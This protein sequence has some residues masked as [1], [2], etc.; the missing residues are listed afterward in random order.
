MRRAT[1]V[2]VSVMAAAA[3]LGAPAAFAAKH[4][5]GMDVRAANPHG[6]V[7]AKGAKS[8]GASA[9][10]NPDMLFH[11]GQ[12]MTT[13]NVTPIYWGTSWGNATFVADKQSGLASFYTGFSDSN[14][15]KTS[16]E[17][18]GTNGT[19]GPSN[20]FTTGITDTSPAP[21][22]APST[23]AVLNEVAKFFPNPDPLGYYPVYVDTKRGSAGYCAWHSYGTI[24]GKPVVFAF[25]FNLDGDPGCDPGNKVA[26]H[27][28]G[29]AALANVS[30]HELSEARTD[31][32]NG[33]WYDASGG[34]NGDKC[35]WTFN[36]PSVT[37]SNGSQWT[38]QGEW[39][40]QAYDSQTGYPN[41]SGQRGCLDG[42]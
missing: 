19:V 38:V 16:D 34:E 42:H 9:R 28:Q 2:I 32:S 40:N 7:P 41:S 3:G 33:G 27:S 22:K 15:A 13:S 17:Y 37:F 35:A 1:A 29:L 4:P 18:G 39:S 31:P 30:A 36:V 6:F 12:I 25:F 14:Y 10:R 23:T 26:T 21:S 8:Q 24:N 11:N 5:D 20:T